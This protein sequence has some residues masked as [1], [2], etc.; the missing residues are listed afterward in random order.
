MLTLGGGIEPI[1]AHKRDL[2]SGLRAGFSL[3]FI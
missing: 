3:H 1:H 2:L